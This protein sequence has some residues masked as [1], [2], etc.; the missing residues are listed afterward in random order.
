MGYRNYLQ[1]IPMEIGNKIRSMTEEELKKAY[2]EGDDE[3]V[4]V[5]PYHLPTKEIYEFGKY[6]D[7]ANEK[8]KVCFFLNLG[9]HKYM[10]SDHEVSLVNENFVK[11]QIEFLHKEI[12]DYYQELYDA[13]SSGL[14]NKDISVIEKSHLFSCIRN[15][16]NCNWKSDYGFTPYSLDKGIPDLVKSD[17]YEYQIFDLVRIYKTFDFDNNYM[18]FTGW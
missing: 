15:K 11:S 10:N 1:S 2:G 9:T 16:L 17:S 3:G 14:E 18:L 7:G 12:G 5:S 13:L 4:F 8:D 6:W